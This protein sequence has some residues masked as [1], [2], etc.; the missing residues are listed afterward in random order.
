MDLR[1]GKLSN[2]LE[3]VTVNVPNLTSATV[4]VWVL[5]GSRDESD[6]HAG[7]S[8]FLEHMGFKGGKKYKTPMAVSETIDAIGGEFNAGTGK[9]YT[10]YY[11]RS[12]SD[13]V[14]TAL[15]VL[16][17]MLLCPS[18]KQ[19]DIDREKG[20]I[21]EEI[22]MYE[23][24][25]Q[26][27]VHE[28]FENVIYAGH[29]L[30]RDIIGTKKTV[31]NLTRQN[32]LEYRKRNYL[33][34][35]MLVSIVGGISHK[36]AFELVSEFFNATKPGKRPTK[37]QFNQSQTVPQQKIIT[38]KIEQA[39]SIIGFPSYKLGS[40]NRYVLGVLTAILGGGMSSRLFTEVREK[41][42]LCYAIS[43]SVDTNI[44]SGYFSVYVGTDPGKAQKALKVIL[45]ELYALAKKQKSKLVTEKELQK[46]KEYAKGHFALAMEDSKYITRFVAD[47]YL[48][49]GRTRTPDDYIHGI[50]AVSESDIYRVAKEIFAPEKIN[51]ASIGPFTKK[52]RPQIS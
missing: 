7:I 19:T 23:D 6:T 37:T 5:A 36:K 29:S 47:E 13:N 49:L 17:D 11:V 22:N 3:V 40:E 39:H 24:D 8:H 50:N 16:S 20:V 34:G 30:A 12:A 21:V 44:D 38:K 43:P 18:L 4:S 25:P 46:A 28:Y 2:N 15:D 10:M 48:R 14:K 26:S 27:R 52:N 35:N 31:Q 9:E 1:I 32:L 41:R 42:G 33:S 51:L 45:D